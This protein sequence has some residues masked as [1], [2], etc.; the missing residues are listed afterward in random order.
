MFRTG[1]STSHGFRSRTQEEEDEP[2]EKRQVPPLSLRVHDAMVDQGYSREEV[3][4]LFLPP[5]AAPPS[6]RSKGRVHL[7]LSEVEEVLRLDLG[8]V[9][10]QRELAL[11]VEDYGGGDERRIDIQALLG[12]FGV[13]APHGLEPS[14]SETEDTLGLDR[15]HW[16]TRVRHDIKEEEEE[17][18]Y[19]HSSKRYVGN[20]SVI[21]YSKCSIIITFI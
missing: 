7:Q 10:S 9:L 20:H 17:E 3:V 8:L 19:S 4:R 16:A 5:S 1:S 12:S 18:G 2:L 13:W 14:P 21:R 6:S 15:L 11:I